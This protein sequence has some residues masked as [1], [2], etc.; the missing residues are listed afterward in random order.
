M[1]FREWACAAFGMVIIVPFALVAIPILLPVAIATL[2]VS[3]WRFWRLRTGD[4]LGTSFVVLHPP[5]EASDF[6]VI[7]MWPPYVLHVW[8]NAG[9]ARTDLFLEMPV[10]DPVRCT[11]RLPLSKVAEM[12]ADTPGFC[13]CVH[14]I[15]R[16]IRHADRQTGEVARFWRRLSVFELLRPVRLIQRAWRAH[17]ARRRQAAARVITRA[18]LHFLYRPGGR[19]HEAALHRWHEHR[20]MHEY[21]PEG[22]TTRAMDG[23]AGNGH[24]EVVRLHDPR[25]GRGGSA[26]PPGGDALAART[27]YG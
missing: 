1:H 22:C 21:R 8:G 4:V 7:E 23:A 9:D 10:C 16:S 5:N 26:G 13:V 6:R 12:L 19:G 14:D 2:T 27:P 17:A 25:D 18:A 11:R 15:D 3:T 20:W 24:L